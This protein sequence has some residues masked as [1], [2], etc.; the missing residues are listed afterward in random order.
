LGAERAAGIWAQA[1][2]SDPGVSESELAFA[3]EAQPV[4]SGFAIAYDKL[5]RREQEVL[6][7]LCQHLTD[8]EIAERLFIGRRTAETHVANVL[9]KL[10][11]A[12]RRE[13]AAVAT[14]QGLF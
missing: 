8:S 1:G 12:S 7:L 9:R 14:R 11:V 13:A 6:S 10:G 2:A 5:S 4:R 3:I